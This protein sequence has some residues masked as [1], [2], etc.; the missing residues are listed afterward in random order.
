[1][2]LITDCIKEKYTLRY[3]GGLVLDIVHM[4]VKGQGV[5]VSPVTAISKAKLRRLYE[6]APIALI[7]ECLGGLAIN[8]EDGKN[9]LEQPIDKCDERSGMICGTLEEVKSVKHLLIE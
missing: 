4:L 1:M 6:L 3:S 2:Q 9:I 8:S 7:M 5:Y